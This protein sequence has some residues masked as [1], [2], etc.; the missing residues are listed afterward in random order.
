VSL[1]GHSTPAPNPP[2]ITAG[3]P[4][5]T[6]TFFCDADGNSC[7]NHT[8]AA[9]VNYAAARSAC[10]A[11]GGSL[12]RYSSRAK[13]TDVESYFSSR[14]TLAGDMYWQDISRESAGAPL[15]SSDG[16]AVPAEVSNE[17]PY[18]HWDPLYLRTASQPSY[19]CGIAAADT[20]YDLFIGGLQQVNDTRY[21]TRQAG[22]LDRR[23]GWRLAPC[24]VMASFICE[25]PQY[26]YQCMPPPSPPPSP[27]SPPPPP[28]PPAPPTC[29]PPFN[30]TFFCDASGASCYSWRPTAS[31]S[32][33]AARTACRGIGGELVRYES[34]PEQLQVERWAAGAHGDALPAPGWLC[35]H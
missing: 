24:N 35:V 8:A 17:A 15:Q 1:L 25:V 29:A 4:R 6:R 11:Q 23:Y 31:V 34:G 2:T 9:R 19:L 16:T 21:Y 26:V 13:Q 18:A 5:P 33:S 7:Y 22:N 28:A 14:G 27:P 30:K 12:V 20:A 10:A 32:F 3:A